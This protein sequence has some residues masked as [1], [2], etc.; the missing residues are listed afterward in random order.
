M[1]RKKRLPARFT[2]K[3]RSCTNLNLKVFKPRCL[4]EGRA[5][6]AAE[7]PFLPDS[8]FRIAK[9]GELICKTALAQVAEDKTL[10]KIILVNGLTSLGV[11]PLGETV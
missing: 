1:A 3:D 6:R 4:Q 11:N 9:W 10:T 2:R 7:E 5:T 8:E